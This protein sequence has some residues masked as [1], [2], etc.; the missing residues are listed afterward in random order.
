MKTRLDANRRRSWPSLVVAVAALASLLTTNVV[1]A[2]E[3]HYGAVRHPELLACD[4]SS[5]RG[6]FDDAHACYRILLQADVPAE[7]HAEA[8]WALNDLQLA[9]RLFRE[10]TAARPDDAAIR[11]RWGDLFAATHQDAEAMTI[12]REALNIDS[13]NAFAMLGAA[14]VLVGGFDDAANTYL[15]P[16]LTDT[17]KDPGARAAAW[18]VVARVSL[19][20]NSMT[21]ALHALDEAE[22]ILDTTDWPPLE[23]YALRAAADLLNNMPESGYTAKAL[24][25]NPG[26]GGIYAIPAHFHVITRRYRDAIALYQKAVDIEPGL[27]QAHEE[28]GINLL[29]D[30]QIARARKHLETAYEADPF[31]PAT[32]NTLRLLDS[33]DNF[34]L[35]ND[36]D[37]PQPGLL[38]ITL[39]LHVDEA[40]V[41]A[42]YAVTLAR[43]SIA[44][45]SRRYGF[46]LQEPVIIEM[47]PDHED[48]AVRTAGMPGIGILGATFGYVIAMDSPSSRPPS[49]F[50][51]GTTLWHEMAHVFTLEATDHRVP[52]WFSEGISVFEEWRSGPNPGVRIPLTV[53]KAMQEDRFLPIAE[54]DEGFVRPTYDEQVIVSYMQA[55][56]VCQFIDEAYGTDKLREVLYSF[57]D[58][59]QTGEAISVALDMSPTDFDGEFSRFV[60]REHGAV[61]ANLDDWQRMQQSVGQYLDDQDWE[62]IVGLA[63]H[64]ISILPNYVEP[65][66][67][68]IALAKAN[69]ELGRHADAL[70]AL[71]RY[72]QHGG[73]DPDALRRLGGW[74]SEAGR[75]DEAI[76]VLS[77]VTLVDPLEQEL[78][79]SLGDLLLAA[80]RPD[81][82]LREYTIALA[83]DPHDKATAYYRMAQAHNALG[84][85]EAS[86][87]QLLQALDLAPNFRPAQRL[88]LELM[89]ADGGSEQ[90]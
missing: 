57:R 61:L 3:L 5:W 18:L 36:P 71:E 76:A 11:V 30:N 16:L 4:Q 78:H 37:L 25:Y 68:Y 20:S 66:S 54:L 21:Q 9:N 41:I 40:A 55:G 32:V 63:E 74:L 35:I 39:R 13:D 67:P 77:A 90:N 52:R 65:D 2:R 73:Y 89:R 34:R 33:F 56:L 59:M 29:R 53:Y 17:R 47:Y 80:E 75:R 27:A 69:E 58:G 82:A 42:P 15:E 86:Q 50:Q 84:N 46:D 24:E 43:Q 48:F 44:E 22:A 7:I 26:F 8:A 14:R 70:A 85:R 12:Y 1:I 49:Q 23:L 10:A 60:E 72:W 83:L 62:A 88:L 31:S 19:E 79:G 28:L 64:M 81:D 87:G 6:A 51:W 45:F 38:P